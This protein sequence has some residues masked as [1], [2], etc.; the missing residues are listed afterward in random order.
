MVLLASTND[1]AATTTPKPTLQKTPC[2]IEISASR[3]T[4]PDEYEGPCRPETSST[5]RVGKFCPVAKVHLNPPSSEPLRV[6][7]CFRPL[8][9]KRQSTP[10]PYNRSWTVQRGWRTSRQH[11]GLPPRRGVF[12]GQL[13][14]HVPNR[15]GRI[16]T[17]A[18]TEGCKYATSRSFDQIT[19]T[20]CLSNSVVTGTFV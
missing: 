19:F 10:R 7:A 11:L 16:L 6:P 4:A 9:N 14:E 3:S 17:T 20:A 15:K 1:D 18:W 8:K 2:L 13:R 12:M 5:I